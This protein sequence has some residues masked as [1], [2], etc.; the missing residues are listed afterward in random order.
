MNTTERTLGRKIAA[1]LDRIIGEYTQGRPGPEFVIFGGMHGNEPAG[2]EAS[3]RV[4]RAL[5]ATKRPIR[6]RL[7]AI[8]G[9]VAA[10]RQG[11]RY[12]DRDLNRMWTAEALEALGRQDP[13][14]D[15]T[16]G[17]EQR[18]LLSLIDTTIQSGRGPIVVLDLHSTSAPSGPFS[19][20][21]DTLQNRRVAFALPVPI[22][23]GFEEAIEGTL[24]EYFGER[25]LL[26][27]VFEGGQHGEAATADNMESAIW[28]TLV[29]AGLLDAADVPELPD[30]RR[31]LRATSNGAPIV[32]VTHRHGLTDDDEFAMIDG[33][34][35]FQR[36]QKGQVLARDRSGDVLAPATGILLMPKYQP[37][38]NDGFFVGRRVKKVWLRLSMILRKLG[39]DRLL[40]LF[41][42]VHR[43]PETPTVLYA[44]TRVARWGSRKIFHLFGFRTAGF[45]GP[46]RVFTRRPEHPI[47]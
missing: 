38:G 4:L 45:E 8:A 25:G 46:F 36:V 35:N 20:I 44:D 29:A 10:L 9:N 30:Q 39:A 47:V 17:R 28:I 5:E 23:L 1:D 2:V 16:E 43:S 21:S 6:G 32:E 19:L 34:V 7:T 13:T 22:I 24:A 11:E 37:M 26:A 42:G 14:R 18:H 40:H 27:V 15:D 12:I 31:R 33:F 41:P 3:V